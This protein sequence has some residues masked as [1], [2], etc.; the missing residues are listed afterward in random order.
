[1][2]SAS[3]D[4]PS[5]YHLWVIRDSGCQEPVMLVRSTHAVPSDRVFNAVYQA[6]YPD[7]ELIKRLVGSFSRDE[8]F[9]L[10]EWETWLA[11]GIAPAIEIYVENF[12]YYTPDTEWEWK[13]V[14][15]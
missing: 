15:E 3:Y 2:I 5:S 13:R 1:M 4:P 12:S 6:L 9:T 7:R 14:T 10:H 8:G 11:F